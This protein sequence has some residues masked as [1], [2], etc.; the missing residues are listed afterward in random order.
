MRLR[1]GAKH[2]TMHDRFAM[3]PDVYRFVVAFCPV[4]MYQL[5]LYLTEDENPEFKNSFTVH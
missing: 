3:T 1:A 5:D 4:P 2:V